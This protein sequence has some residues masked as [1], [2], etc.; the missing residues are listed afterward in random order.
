VDEGIGFIAMGNLTYT[1][2]GG[3]FDQATEILAKAGAVTRRQP[4][5]SP[6]LLAARDDVTSLIQRWDDA[7][8]DRIAAVNLFLDE[9]KDRR[10]R[11]LETLRTEYGACKPEGAFEIENALRGQWTLR[12]DRGALRV[13]ITLAPTIPPK[14]QYLSVTPA[15]ATP[16]GRPCGG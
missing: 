10:R 6:A 15:P 13:A 16:P 2:W 12:C 14:V 9:S 1:S 11:Q 3:V 5:P 7:L 8:A 4:D